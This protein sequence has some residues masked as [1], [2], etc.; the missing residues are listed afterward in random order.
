MKKI[1][2]LFLSFTC[3]ILAQDNEFV[4]TTTQGHALNSSEVMSAYNYPAR[5]DTHHGWT[6]FIAASFIYWQ[7]SEGGL[8][9]GHVFKLLK[10]Q[11]Q[12]DVINMNFKYK[13]GF[14]VAIGTD[15][16]HDDWTINAK[17][18]W[19][20]LSEPVYQEYLSPVFIAQGWN[21][22]SI[23]THSAYA[24]WR[25]RYDMIDL[26]MTRS[27]YLGTCLVLKPFIS[28]RGGLIKQYYDGKYKISTILADYSLFDNTQKSWLV[29]PRIGVDG[30]WIIIDY[31]RVI[32]NFAASLCYQNFKNTF[33][34]SY[35]IWNGHEDVRTIGSIIKNKNY[36]LTPNV[37]AVLGL[38]IGDYFGRTNNWHLDL[39]LL[40]EVHYFFNQN[41]MRTLNEKSIQDSLAYQHSNRYSPAYKADDLMMHGLTITFRCDF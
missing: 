19:L 35:L 25:L 18:T 13:C 32:T 9:L 4:V 24:V 23:T 11:E 17:Y 20:H 26:E 10:P 39:S 2:V 5:I 27:Y 22:Y 21:F 3:L 12:Y 6:P 38:G 40:Y 36:Q 30:D 14:K 31:C 8:D 41:Y 15:I 16:N 37:E 7:A 33:C 1:L 29:G 28:L 34:S